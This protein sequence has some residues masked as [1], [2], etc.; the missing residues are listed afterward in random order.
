MELN[1]WTLS[2]LEFWIFVFRRTNM[3]CSSIAND[4]WWSRIFDRIFGLLRCNQRK[5]MHGSHCKLHNIQFEDTAAEQSFSFYSFRFY[6]LWY[7]YSKLES[8][9][10]AIQNTNNWIAFWTKVSMKHWTITMGIKKHGNLFKM[11]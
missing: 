1:R 9:S 8:E 10:L 7:S 11:R 3:V 5:L 6:W 4:H 2:F